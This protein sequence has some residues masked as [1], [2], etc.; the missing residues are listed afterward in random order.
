M[1]IDKEN[2]AILKV[3]EN[4]ETSLSRDEINKYF[5]HEE[6]MR[7]ISQATSKQENTVEFT[8][9]NNDGKYYATKYFTRTI[10]EKITDSNQFENSLSEIS[11]MAFDF[12]IEDVELLE[13]EH[14]AKNNTELNRVLYDEKFWDDFIYR[15]DAINNH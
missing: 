5:K 10:I 9:V 11:S 8:Q 3:V 7:N 15:N 2:F 1:Y 13:Y 14:R 12:E 6:S 4:W